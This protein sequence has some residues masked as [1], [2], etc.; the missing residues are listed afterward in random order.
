[1]VGEMAVVKSLKKEENVEFV[2]AETR[3]GSWAQVGKEY[4]GN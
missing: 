4:R 3:W 2:E 1:M